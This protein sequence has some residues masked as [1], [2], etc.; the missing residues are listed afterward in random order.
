MNLSVMCLAACSTPHSLVHTPN[1]YTQSNQ[2]YPSDSVSEAYQNVSPELFFVTDRKKD[3]N[4]RYASARSPS[5]SFGKVNVD[6]GDDITWDEL[7][8]LSNAKH[9]DKDITLKIS[10]TQELT[11]FPETPLPFEMNDV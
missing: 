9:R 6:F 11:R 3:E 4:Q 1:L 5:M 10:Q 7:I 2:T 8:T